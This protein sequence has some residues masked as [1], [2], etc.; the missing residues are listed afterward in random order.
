[1]YL[2]PFSHVS[3][4]LP[5][6]FFLSAHSDRTTWM[7]GS[8]EA[9]SFSDC[10]LIWMMDSAVFFVRYLMLFFSFSV[11]LLLLLRTSWWSDSFR[12]FLLKCFLNLAKTKERGRKQ[13]ACFSTNRG[14][15]EGEPVQM[16]REEQ[17]V[18]VRN[19]FDRPHESQSEPRHTSE[20]RIE[21]PLAIHHE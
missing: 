10:A 16:I 13:T 4:T 7:M 14:Y 17:R 5:Y 8:Q 9:L 6:F 18:M 12:H 3:Y 2:T 19:W 21:I 20:E 1:M 11:L 15:T